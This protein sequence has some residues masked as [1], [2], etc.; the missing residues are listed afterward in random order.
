LR[1][2]TW[3]RE[4]AHEA[5][6]LE[7]VDRIVQAT[8]AKQREDGQFVFLMNYARARGF[9]FQPPRSLF[10]DGEVALM[11]AARRVVREKRAYKPL[12]HER[13]AFISERMKQSPTLCAESYPNECWMFDNAM[14]VAA[15]RLADHLD[16]T[17]HRAFIARWLQRI[18]TRLIE[19]ESG[20]LLSAFGLD[21]H[22]LHGPEGS[23]IWM[24]AHCLRLVDPAFA[25]AQ[26]ARAKHQ[27]ARHL[28]G[29]GYARE[30]PEGH[31][32][33]P[34]I[35][36]GPIVPLLEASPGAS[37]LA[38]LGAASFDDEAYLA[39]L[40]ASL[41]FAAFPRDD[42]GT[43]RYEASNQVGDAVILYAL[44]EGPLWDAV[45]ERSKR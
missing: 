15:M 26:Y 29:L 32:G 3:L 42:D 43:L 35:D 22:P 24:V 19:P 8:L 40:L 23:S 45:I 25:Q 27:L 20:M 16:Q 44:V 41:D 7:V 6:Y 38:L 17:D 30:W 13:L 10:I 5:T 2:A 33:T 34:D 28:L 4:P 9:V 18:K 37:G 31:A 21:G 11:L 12:L 14:A 36:S 39:R 1:S